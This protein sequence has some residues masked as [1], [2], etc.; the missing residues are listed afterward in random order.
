MN[1]EPDCPLVFSNSDFLF[2]LFLHIVLCFKFSASLWKDD[3]WL[4]SQYV[5]NFVLGILGKFGESVKLK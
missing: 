4:L 1:S 3:F 5:L 2:F